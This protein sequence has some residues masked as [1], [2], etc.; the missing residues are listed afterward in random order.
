[1]RLSSAAVFLLVL[2]PCLAW[3]RDAKEDQRIEQLIQAVESLKGA[4]FI[5]NGTEYTASEAGQ[6]LRLKLKGAGARVKTAEDFIEGCASRSSL[7]GAA[8][9]IR[10]AGG[11]LTETGPFFRKKLREFQEARK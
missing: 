3:A 2:L 8:Y 4:T 5:R 11:T 6:H 10:F 7:S 1:M 9:K